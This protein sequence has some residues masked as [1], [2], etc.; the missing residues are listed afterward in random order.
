MTPGPSTSVPV[1]QL[2]TDAALKALF[3]LGLKTTIQNGINS[4][5]VP[6]DTYTVST[7]SSI[8]KQDSQIGAIYTFKCVAANASKK[9]TLTLSFSIASQTQQLTS[10]SISVKS[11]L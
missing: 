11:T 7:V 1:S 2:Q 8:A 9:T 4:G 5:H 3:D 10:Y 6:Q